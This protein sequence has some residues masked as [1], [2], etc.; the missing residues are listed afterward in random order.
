[1]ENLNSFDTIDHI[2][3]SISNLEQSIQWYLSSFACEVIHREKTLA[4]LQF[5][6]IKMVLSLPSDQRP[7]IGF[8]KKNAS[9]FGEI[10]EQ[11]DCCKSTFI[12]DPT[13]NPVELVSE[14]LEEIQPKG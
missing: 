8:V 12:A 4:I 7:H 5:K 1:M 9:E 6:N 2:T 11:S 13:G 14:T 3:I 10:M